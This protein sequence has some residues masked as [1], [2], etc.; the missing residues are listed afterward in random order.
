MKSKGGVFGAASLLLLLA[1]LGAVIFPGNLPHW[2]I[3]LTLAATFAIVS[4]FMHGRPDFCA[5]L[6]DSYWRLAEQEQIQA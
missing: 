1:T 3:F 2:A 4:V 5:T 6:N